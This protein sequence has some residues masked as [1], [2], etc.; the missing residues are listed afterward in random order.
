MGIKLFVDGELVDIKLHNKINL[1]KEMKEA[2]AIANITGTRIND[3]WVIYIDSK[4]N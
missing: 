1:I 4:E 2:K 3:E